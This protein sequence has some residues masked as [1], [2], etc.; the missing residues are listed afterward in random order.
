M[1]VFHAYIVAF[2]ML[3]TSLKGS[4]KKKFSQLS[5]GSYHIAVQFIPSE[6]SLPSLKIIE[7]SEEFEIPLKGYA[8]DISNLV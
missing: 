3:L 2:D 5:A 8:L 6:S 7:R 4:S 1:Y